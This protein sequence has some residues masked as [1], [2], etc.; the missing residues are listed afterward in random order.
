MMTNPNL[1]VWKGPGLIQYILFQEKMPP[2]DNAKF[3]QAIAQLIDRNEVVN[4]VFQGLAA[5]LYSTIPNEMA[6][7]EDAYKALPVDTTP[8]I[9][10]LSAMGYTPTT[11]NPAATYGLAV[12]GLGVV[13][14]IAG[15]ATSRR[16][17][18]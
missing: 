4:T 9:T 17:K 6:Y 16:K 3:R 1:K 14:V 18:T 15:L 7:H 5:P 12:A 2:F 11:E 13:I 10:L 8:A